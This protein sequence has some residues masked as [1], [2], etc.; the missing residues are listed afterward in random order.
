MRTRVSKSVFILLIL[1]LALPASAR[2]NRLQDSNNNY[3]PEVSAFLSLTRDEEEEL[4]FQ[5]Q[6]GEISRKD[7]TRAK[8]KIAIHR[9]MVLHIVKETG[10]DV[11]PELHVVTASEVDQLIEDGTRALK[12]AKP[13]AIIN[14]A[15]KLIAT[16]NRG[17]LFYVFERIAR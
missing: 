13:G 7:Y 15:W 14:D 1:S 10:E 9:Q 11:V 12:G 3:G 6:R 16:V 5:I 17:E 4:E 2:G 8:R